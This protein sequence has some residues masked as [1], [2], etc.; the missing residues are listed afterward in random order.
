[1]KVFIFRVP[2]SKLYSIAEPSTKQNN[3]ANIVFCSNLRESLPIHSDQLD[4]ASF[5]STSFSDG[6]ENN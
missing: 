5:S 2:C 6:V 1:M 3:A 4:M